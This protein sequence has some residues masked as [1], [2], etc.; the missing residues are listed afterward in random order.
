[1]KNVYTIKLSIF[2]DAVDPPL[3]GYEERSLEMHAP[4]EDMSPE[5]LKSSADMLAQNLSAAARDDGE[6]WA[7]G[8]DP[9]LKR[10]DLR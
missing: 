3:G 1:M 5:I 2:K 10:I 7:K 8:F 9:S 4:I 6:L